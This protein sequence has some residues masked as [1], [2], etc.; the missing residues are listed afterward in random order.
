MS[1]ESS[2]ESTQDDRL[3]TLLAYVFSPVIPV[4]ILLLEDKR[5]RPF[6]KAHNAQALIWGLF[7]LFIVAIPSTFCFGIPSIVIWAV[8]VYWGIRAYQGDYVSIPLVTDFVKR[9]GWA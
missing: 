5:D 3:W 4:V 2:H 9:Q 1:D 8:G 6:I 7:N